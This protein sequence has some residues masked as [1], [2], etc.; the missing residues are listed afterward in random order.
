VNGGEQRIK[1]ARPSGAVML[2]H[3][4]QGYR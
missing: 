2:C 3:S 4:P 1:Y